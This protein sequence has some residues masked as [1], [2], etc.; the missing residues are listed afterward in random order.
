MFRPVPGQLSP[1][2]PSELATD[3]RAKKLENMIIT[4]DAVDSSFFGVKSHV[5]ITVYQLSGE[6]TVLV[7]TEDAY[8]LI[9][10][11]SVQTTVVLC[12]FLA[13]SHS[14]QE[15]EGRTLLKN[16]AALNVANEKKR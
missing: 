5:Q 8:Q 6:K 2:G 14:I 12:H 10:Y 7:E 16:S 9:S 11:L 1:S 15:E 4:G 13:K 3:G